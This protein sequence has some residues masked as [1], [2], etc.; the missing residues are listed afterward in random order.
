M[1]ARLSSVF[2]GMVVACLCLC[3]A[4][5][6]YSQQQS[7]TRSLEAT[8]LA[9]LFREEVAP[10][11]QR[12]CADCHGMDVTEADID[13]A[14][15]NS[16]EKMRETLDVWQK[17]ADVLASEE[18]PPADSPQPSEAELLRLRHLIGDF[19]ANE[20][21][22]LAGDPGPIVLRRLSNAE[23]TN[24]VRQLTDIATLDP[25]REFPVDGASGE[26]FT[27]AGNALVMSPALLT[28]YLDAGKEIS[29][30]AVLTP[31]GLRFSA[32]VFRQDWIEETL[33][34]IRSLYAKYSA[35]EGGSEVNLQ[36]IVFNTNDGGRLPIHLY[37][38]ATVEERSTLAED[39]ASFDRVAAERG[40]SA[41]YL[42]LLW[43]SL[44]EPDGLLMQ[45]LADQW[46]TASASDV[47]QL[48]SFI[49]QW[50]DA[51]WKF[52][53]V[54]HIG[55]VNGPAAWM[56]PVTPLASR[57]DFRLPLSATTPGADE[58]VIYLSAGD[59][60]DGAENDEVIWERPRFVAAGRPDLYLKDCRRVGH[61]LALAN[62][63]LLQSAEVALLAA[64]WARQQE[65]L[66]PLAEV[67]ARFNCETQVLAP[68]FEYLGISSGE[69]FRLEGHLAKTIENASGYD[70]VSGWVGDDAL[71]VLANSS[72]NHV[73]V[74]GNLLPHSIAVHPSPTVQIVVGWTS[75]VI[76]AV[77]VSGSVQHAHPECGNGVV[78]ALQLRR[79]ATS[80]TLAT[81]IAHGDNINPIEIPEAIS[82]GKGDILCLVIGPRDGNHSCDLTAINLRIE[83]P[84]VVG[85][86]RVDGNGAAQ[87][88]DLA[89]DVSGDIL[90]GNPHSDAYGN[91]AVWHFCG[92]PVS[93][94]V[95]P[96]IPAGSLL[97]AW[98][99]TNDPAEQSRFGH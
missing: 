31:T 84:S 57:H 58:I 66:P 2:S 21:E 32:S 91:K 78:W 4:N 47:P 30:H 34:S 86:Q 26:G 8:P 3:E 95:G 22:R 35:A 17:V 36:G 43:Q 6:V 53:S 70:F 89:A 15:M 44:R 11:L 54:G 69:S 93:G 71:S 5:R 99:A 28:K 94:Q 68:W 73:R 25:A 37:L 14:S 80:Q 50:Q 38:L 16:M 60:G 20:A 79:G 81:G 77:K 72:A 98:Q 90:A 27:N 29:Q 19:L 52:S 49:R 96:V 45:Q 55:K 97:A 39:E 92:E 33:A 61:S 59:A 65:A 67:A 82:V 51:L 76:G 10:L 56:E 9:T 64:S 85:E 48:T 62:K 41:K 12:Y 75:P 74:P 46:R 63:Q 87:V 40:I 42:R 7:T 88:W 1:M 23:Y 18:M 83:Q 24:S 13:F